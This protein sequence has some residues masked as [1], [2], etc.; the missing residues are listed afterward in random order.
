[1]RWSFRTVVVSIFISCMVSND[2]TEWRPPTTSHYQELWDTCIHHTFQAIPVAPVPQ[3]CC[4][5]TNITSRINTPT[6]FINNYALWR[7]SE[8][9]LLVQMSRYM[10]IGVV[11]DVVP[12]PYRLQRRIVLTGGML[13]LWLWW[14]LWV[15]SYCLGVNCVLCCAWEVVLACRKLVSLCWLQ[16]EV[17]GGYDE[18]WSFCWMGII[19]ATLFVNLSL[20]TLVK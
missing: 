1:M 6:S 10:F 14:S 16:F 4:T 11:F 2:T 9:F 7:L 5:I 8:W 19:G 13:F 20:K 15:F 18:V 3:S 17:L 12:H